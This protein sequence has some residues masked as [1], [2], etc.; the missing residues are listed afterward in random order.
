MND[1]KVITELTGKRI[2]LVHLASVLLFLLSV[3]VFFASSTPDGKQISVIMWL[4]SVI[5]YVGA[6]ISKWWNHS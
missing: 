3:A 1:Q 5:M 6:S 4:I 2:K